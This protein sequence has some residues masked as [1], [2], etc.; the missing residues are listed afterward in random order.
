MID[1]KFLKENYFFHHH[2]AETET[3]F[4]FCTCGKKITK[5]NNKAKDDEVRIEIESNPYQDIDIMDRFEGAVNV[6]CPKCKED[7]SKRKNI[8]RIKETNS[9]FYGYFDF[10]IEGDRITLYKN[11]I[12]SSCTDNSR[13]VKFKDVIS[14]ISVDSKTKKLYHKDYSSKKEKEF[15]L[16]EL[17]KVMKDFYLG[18]DNVELSV[19]DRIINVHLFLSELARLVV[20]SENMD[21]IEGLMSQMIGK[22][23]ID[24]LMKLNTIFFGIICYSNLSTIALTK[25]TVFLYDM[26]HNCKLP[27]PNILS[28]EGVTSPLKIFNFLVTLENEETQKEIESEKNESSG[29]VYKSKDGKM[30]KNLNFDLE[31]WGFNRESSVQ[32]S[33]GKINVRE[34]LKNKTVSKYIFN[35]IE[36][37]EDYKKLIRFTKFISYEDLISLVMKYEVEYIIN[38]FNLVEFRDDINM[39]SLRQ[40]IPLTLDYLRKKPSSISSVYNLLNM[41]RDSSLANQVELKEVDEDEDEVL[42][43]SLNYSLLRNFSF[44]EYDDSVRM[45]QELKWDRTREFDKIKKMSELKTYHDKL[46]AHYNM[47]SDREK[48]EKFIKFAEKFKYLENY[49]KPIKIKLLSMPSMVLEYAKEMKNCAGSYVTRI[50]QG[51]YLLLMIYDKTQEKVAEEHTKFMMGLNVTQAGLEFEQFKAPCNES[52]SNR[53]K[54]LIME[55]LEDKDISYREVRDLKIS[56]DERGNLGNIN[57]INVL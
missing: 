44:Y 17:V 29:F 22:P 21:I 55:Y 31:K 19:I 23:G 9:Y 6:I 7:Y 14:Y 28:D 20:D 57:F 40:I 42:E 24:V 11:K 30:L 13:Y 2:N 48:N 36:K 47:L 33:D 27:N 15:N 8:Q 26:M 53:Q 46:V 35:K 25:G 16:D 50:S 39:Y 37:F 34:D 4:Y 32:I 5:K 56:D 10:K 38:L 12:K 43:Q 1:T 18:S 45:I 51:K 52:A 54:K 3:E 49:E 41:T